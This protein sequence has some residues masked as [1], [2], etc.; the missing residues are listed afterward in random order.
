MHL[1]RSASLTLRLLLSQ[2][3]FRL[4]STEVSAFKLHIITTNIKCKYLHALLRTDKFI[5]NHCWL[6]EKSTAKD[7]LI[8]IY[9]KFYTVESQNL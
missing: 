7:D 5:K 4:S 9:F 2:N 3:N 1:L 8:K 6:L